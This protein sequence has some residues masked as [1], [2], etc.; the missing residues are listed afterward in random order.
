LKSGVNS[1]D[2]T[3]LS[4]AFQGPVTSTLKRRSTRRTNS[5]SFPL[6]ILAISPRKSV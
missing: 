1:Y 6:S 5:C 2:S 3:L 4:R